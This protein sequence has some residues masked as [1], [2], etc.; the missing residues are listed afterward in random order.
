MA[1]YGLWQWFNWAAY[2]SLYMHQSGS[3]IS[4]GLVHVQSTTN[5]E[6][7]IFLPL[8]SFQKKVSGGQDDDSSAVG[9]GHSPTTALYTAMR[10][11][12]TVQLKQSGSLLR[13]IFCPDLITPGTGID[14]N[15]CPWQVVP[16]QVPPRRQ[17]F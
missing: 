11:A 12:G 16:W 6:F 9:C 14:K 8:Y 13:S 15:N 4:P 5:S 10:G 1:S 7:P 3:L 2:K 17:F